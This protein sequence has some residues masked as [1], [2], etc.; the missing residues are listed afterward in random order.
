MSLK[1]YDNLSS[2]ISFILSGTSKE[3]LKVL[4]YLGL[5]N[6]ITLQSNYTGIGFDE[7]GNLS[8]LYK[9]GTDISNYVGVPS[10]ERYSSKNVEELMSIV[11][12]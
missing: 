5:T 1:L 10:L 4:K 2:S 12:G 8:R 7:D 9:D 6:G 11:K 3:I